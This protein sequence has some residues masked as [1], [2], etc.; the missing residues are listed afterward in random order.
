MKKIILP[1]LIL[2]ININLYSTEWSQTA[3]PKKSGNYVTAN[4]LLKLPN[5]NIICTTDG[6]GIFISTNNGDSWSQVHNLTSNAWSIGR[7]GN[8]RI[9]V[10]TDNDG[11]YRSTDNGSTF[12]KVFNSTSMIFD[13]AFNS[14][15]HIY[16]ASELDGIYVSTNNGSNWN[17]LWSMDLI[18]I[19]IAVNS[20]DDIFVGTATDGLYISTDGGLT[21]DNIGFSGIFIWDIFIDEND[22]LYVCSETEGLNK[23]T[24]NG[25]T[26]TNLG[27]P[28]SSASKYFRSNSGKQFLVIDY[29]EIYRYN[30][31]SSMWEYYAD[32][33]NGNGINDINEN[34]NGYLLAATYLDGVY[35]SNVSQLDPEFIS[36]TDPNAQ[37]CAGEFFTLSYEVS[38][39]FE[40]NNQFTIQISDATGNFDNP[41]VLGSINSNVSGTIDCVIPADLDGGLNYYYRIVSSHPNLIGITKGN[42]T[43]NALT[44]TLL[45]PTNNATGISLKPTFEWES[46]DCALYYGIEI[47]LVSDFST[48]VY[49]DDNLSNNSYTLPIN[50]QKNTQYY[51]RIVLTSILGDIQYTSPFTFTTLN[52]VTQTINLT[53]GWNMIS[54]YITMSNMNIANF[55]SSIASDMVIAK[56][57]AGQVYIPAFDINTIGNWNSSQGYLIFMSSAKQLNLI[58]TQIEPET[59]SINLTSG[60]N[61][62]SYLRNSPMNAATAFA[63]LTDNNNL[64]IAKNLAGQVYIPSFGINTIGNLQPGQGYLIFVNN[65]DSFS[66]PAN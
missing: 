47:S 32:G 30:N 59:Y 45:Y 16:A 17:L 38:G 51:W 14:F 19:S 39:G 9:F 4:S 26:W 10:G 49:S 3:G 23:S 43:V 2:I 56:N 21:F 8:G 5:N 24:D 36:I 33:L 63:D 7:S 27:F 20:D 22:N 6:A 29:T 58:G 54:S 40:T 42:F 18:P 46:N 64:V 53:S 15:N 1:I 50:L 48:L 37:Y 31:S 55:L 13:F 52:E 11:I 57:Q 65:S 34:Q 61:R 12:T 66:Y 44:T 28:S 35:K 60:W 62:I 41:I 25:N